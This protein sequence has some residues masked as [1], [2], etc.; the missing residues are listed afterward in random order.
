M[1]TSEVGPGPR[2]S[3][4]PVIPYF[5]ERDYTL[6]YTTTTTTTTAISLTLMNIDADVL[7]GICCMSV[8]PWVT[9]PSTTG[10]SHSQLMG[11][12]LPSYIHYYGTLP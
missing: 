10:S 9:I 4:R 3:V 7:H 1:R 8:H 5:V 12:F 11:M 2:T 6:C